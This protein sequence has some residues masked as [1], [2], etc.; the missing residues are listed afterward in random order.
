MYKISKQETNTKEKIIKI[1]VTKIIANIL[2]ENR[3]LNYRNNYVNN[4]NKADMIKY[5]SLSGN[6]LYK[7][8]SG[9]YLV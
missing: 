5:S 7:I 4:R 2:E 3:R 6:I 9:R 8:Y 1:K